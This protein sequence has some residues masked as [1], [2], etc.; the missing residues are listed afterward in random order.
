[1]GDEMMSDSYRVQSSPVE[2]S[3]VGRK[4]CREMRL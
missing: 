4:L 1:M 2:S 3:R